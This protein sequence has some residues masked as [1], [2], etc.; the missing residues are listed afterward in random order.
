[1]PASRARLAVTLFVILSLIPLQ[2]LPRNISS[3]PSI[4]PLLAPSQL[5]S[6]A[7]ALAWLSANQSSDGSY[8]PYFEGEAAA[9]AYAFWL[10]DSDSRNATSSYTY[11]AGQLNSSSTWFWNFTE[12]D[13]PGEILLSIGLSEH[14]GMIQNL[15]EVSSRL[16]QLQ[17]PNGGFEG[18]FDPTI[19]PCDPGPCG[20]TVTSSVDTAMAL[21]G[22]SNAETIPEDGRTAAVRYL[23]TLQN[24][25]GSFNLTRTTKA[26]SLSSLG[27][28]PVS[29]T[30]LA[31]TVLHD[32]GF[33]QS[34]PSISTALSFLNRAASASFNGRGHVYDAA[35]S[36]LAF[37]QYNHACDAVRTLTYLIAQQNSDGGFR[38]M[39][40]GPGSN[41]LDTG[42]AAIALQYGITDGVGIACPPNPPPLS[43]NQPPRAKFSFSP[44][45]P[46]NG[47]TVSFDSRPSSDADG[48]SLS[49][50]WTFGDGG[51]AAGATP[52]HV[53][54]RDGTYTVTLTVTDN[55]TN[56]VHLSSTM[57][58]TVN[59]TQS[60]APAKT[61][62]LPTSGLNIIE[63]VVIVA[64]AT[65][66]AGS[67]LFRI[68]RRRALRR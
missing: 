30:A 31:T 37:L 43:V 64:L 22:L 7:S 57:W 27:P 36:T 46:T 60:T 53:F 66:G 24:T 12:A 59:V 15:S 25:D 67:L 1:M 32:N 47:A 58:R 34:D 9:A 17:L 28:D 48:D 33:K 20:R 62:T 5:P 29:I 52:I 11:L 56:P 38:D 55:G 68:R 19:G 39:T 61:P 4:I 14:L 3:Q 44:S 45:Q 42:W 54:A 26:N 51:S 13:V 18:Y 16:L 21:W 63:L 2:P 65:L 41:A 35:L 49:Y 6:V 50:A 10:N 40:R 8:G 23:L